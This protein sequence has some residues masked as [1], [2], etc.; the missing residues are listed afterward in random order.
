MFSLREAKAEKLSPLVRE[1]RIERPLPA[2]ALKPAERPASKFISIS[3]FKAV[4]D[5]ISNSRS[6]LRDI[7]SFFD[8]IEEVKLNEDR[9]YHEL[10]SS[11]E[12]LHRKIVFIDK[13]L[14]EEV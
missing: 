8:R 10:H 1:I 7:D 6:D 11:L 2:R 14:F 5:D 12:E 9:K 13:T 4:Q 3:S